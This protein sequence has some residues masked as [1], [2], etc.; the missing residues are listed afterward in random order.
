MKEVIIILGSDKME[1]AF[2]VWQ[3]QWIKILIDGLKNKL[4]EEQITENLN[5]FVEDKR[6]N[7]IKFKE[8]I[9]KETKLYEEFL[10]K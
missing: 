6:L 5:N 9:D 2:Q 1:Y 4:T 8:Q 3:S 10:T 7:M